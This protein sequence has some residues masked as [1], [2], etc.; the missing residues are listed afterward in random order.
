MLP[1]WKDIRVSPDT[2]RLCTRNAR[3][4]TCHHWFAVR[5]R[6]LLDIYGIADIQV[7][8]LIHGILYITMLA[9]GDLI[10]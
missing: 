9:E 6:K 1:N 5:H 7:H 3:R 10:D 8:S 4:D 2:N